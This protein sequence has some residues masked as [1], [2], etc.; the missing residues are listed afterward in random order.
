[1]NLKRKSF[2]A[3]VI[4]ATIIIPSATDISFAN[5]ENKRNEQFRNFDYRIYGEKIDKFLM[6]NKISDNYQL[7]I[8]RVLW[9]YCFS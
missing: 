5:I 7:Q 4:L 9:E 1:M 8:N 6:E 2:I 3:G